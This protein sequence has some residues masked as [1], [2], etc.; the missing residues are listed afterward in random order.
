MRDQRTRA[1]P[2]TRLHEAPGQRCA[3]G[4]HGRD[5]QGI[6]RGHV[7]AQTTQ[8]AL[9][10]SISAERTDRL[11]PSPVRRP[12]LQPSAQ[13]RRRRGSIRT[14]AVV[15]GR[16]LCQDSQQSQVNH[17]KITRQQCILQSPNA[18][19]EHFLTCSF[20]WPRLNN[21]ASDSSRIKEKYVADHQKNNC[22][23]QNTKPPLSNQKT[24]GG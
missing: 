13:L 7:V 22:T 19:V 4:E 3:H 8:F 14:K 11:R 1:L 20:G 10:A 18:N 6:A 21:K 16:S 17:H 15:K 12:K 2:L 24:D 5:L 9:S 23:D